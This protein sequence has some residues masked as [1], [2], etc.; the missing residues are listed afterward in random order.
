MPNDFYTLSQ[1]GKVNSLSKLY[2]FY[3]WNNYIDGT[4]LGGIINWDDSVNTQ[5]KLPSYD[6]YPNWN[7]PALLS[8]WGESTLSAWY[9][10]NG[11]VD[12]NIIYTMSNGLGILSGVE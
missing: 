2:T 4:I 3:K 8:S 7:S 9:D 12:R 1:D 6:L 5:I 10:D 11:Y